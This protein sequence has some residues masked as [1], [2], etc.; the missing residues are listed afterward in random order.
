MGGTHSVAVE[1]IRE[2]SRKSETIIALCRNHSE[3]GE[4]QNSNCSLLSP[5][6]S[7]LPP[8]RLPEKIGKEISGPGQVSRFDYAE[9]HVSVHQR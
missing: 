2:R 4:V 7:R 8:A 6:R 5:G 1:F 9:N 3:L